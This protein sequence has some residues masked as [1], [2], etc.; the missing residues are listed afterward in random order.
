[1]AL[2]TTCWAHKTLRAFY[3]QFYFI[4]IL[5]ESLGKRPGWG[6]SRFRA[7]HI[8]RSLAGK[9]SEN[10]G[11]ETTGLVLLNECINC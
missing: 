8:A 9:R 5:P 6:E 1:M 2:L 4:N 10:G 7:A 3:C 11:R